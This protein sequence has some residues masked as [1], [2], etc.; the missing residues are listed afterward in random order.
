MDKRDKI[1]NS[2]KLKDSDSN[3]DLPLLLELLK[4]N[5]NG[6][7]TDP[8]APKEL[9]KNVIFCLFNIFY[10]NNFVNKNV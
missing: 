6:A 2:L 8:F 3:R 7:N 10:I 4:N 5:S 9:K 1:A